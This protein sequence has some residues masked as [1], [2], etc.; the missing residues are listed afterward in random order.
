M[1]LDSEYLNPEIYSW[2][3]MLKIMKYEPSLT[4]KGNQR[5]NMYNGR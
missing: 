4:S 2:E 1:C 3:S 5:N